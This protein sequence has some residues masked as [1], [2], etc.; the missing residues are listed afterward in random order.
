MARIFLIIATVIAAIMANAAA[1][2]DPVTE[3]RACR[4][5]SDAERLACF[6]RLLARYEAATQPVAAAQPVSPPAAVAQP[7]APAD[8]GSERLPPEGDAPKPAE[9]IT[10]KVAAVSFNAI[11]HFTVTLDNGQVWRQLESDTVTARLK[12][13]ET[14]T[15]TKG[16][17]SSYSLAVDGVWGTYK[18]KR[19]K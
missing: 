13:A 4:A 18:V 19:I 16:F 3:M 6:D 11:A 10:A 12:G 8:F 5:L 1:A 7:P 2:A 17:W 14:V 9:F 15:I